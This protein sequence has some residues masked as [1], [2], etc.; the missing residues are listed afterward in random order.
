MVR[1]YLKRSGRV[2]SPEV[3][4]KAVDNYFSTKDGTKKTVSL[5]GKPRTTLRD[6]VKKMNKIPDPQDIC[7]ENIYVDC[8]KHRQVFSDF[9]EHELVKYIQHASRIYFG[10]SPTKVRVLAYQGAT[11]YAI[12]MPL[13]WSEMG[14]VGCDWF[15]GF[16]KRHPSLSIRTPEATI[17]GRATAFNR[18]TIEMFYATLASVMDKHKFEAKDIWNVDETGITTVQKPNKIVATTG[19]KQVGMLVSAERGTRITVCAAVSAVGQS[20][21]PFF[22]FP[23]V[24]FHDHFLKGAPFGSAGTAHKSGWMTEENF[25]TFL[26]HFHDRVRCTKESPLLILLDNH[27][28]HLAIATLDYAK[29]NGIVLMSFPP[30]CSHKLQPLDLSVF[31]PL[32]KRTSRAQQNW[33]RNHPS[34]GMTIYDI[35]DIV[36][37]AWTD[38]V[39]P[40]NVAARF[41]KAGVFPF[42]RDLFTDLEFAP[43]SVADRPLTPA[44]STA[45]P[46]VL[47][48][49]AELPLTQVLA[50]PATVPVPPM[51]DTTALP[52]IP[53][54]AAIPR[55]Q[56]SALRRDGVHEHVTN[57]RMTD[58]TDSHPTVEP[59]HVS[60]YILEGRADQSIHNEMYTE[61]ELPGETFEE[62]GIA[63]FMMP[64]SVYKAQVMISP[65]ST[66]AV[67]SRARLSPTWHTATISQQ[68]TKM[69]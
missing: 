11:Q 8:A 61:T 41:V 50:M 55:T 36:G 26:K 31:G 2:S 63:L 33:T 25:P 35:P 37:E 17:I 13:S 1:N 57:I 68:M 32:E 40:R 29:E 3:I 15:T 65:M 24:T 48:A 5:F 34:V 46:P 54:T 52:P 18:P 64:F 12:P 23:R 58:K 20:L 14:R 49:A 30:H 21:H 38:S 47:P 22:V 7:S 60:S 4:R 6:H 19:A 59:A 56:P 28:S 44:R 39:T 67:H 51:P 27:S 66:F 42:N 43:S 53:D 45:E 10:L 9:Q 16:L 62:M 69:S